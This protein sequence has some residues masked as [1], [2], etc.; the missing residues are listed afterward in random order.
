M[1]AFSAIIFIGGIILLL[2]WLLGDDNQ[3]MLPRQEE[4]LWQEAPDAPLKGGSEPSKRGPPAMMNPSKRS[5]KKAPL[6]EI[7]D[8]TF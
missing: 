7:P 8:E 2:M 1:S 4:P 3:V 6:K 5:R